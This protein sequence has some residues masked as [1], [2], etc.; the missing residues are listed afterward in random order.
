MGAIA[1]PLGIRIEDFGQDLTDPKGNP[2]LMINFE[3]L[4]GFARSSKRSGVPGVPPFDAASGWDGLKLWRRT[5]VQECKALIE[6]GT[7]PFQQERQDTICTGVVKG[8]PL[9]AIYDFCQWLNEGKGYFDPR[10]MCDCTPPAAYVYGGPLP[11]FAC[12]K[13][14]ENDPS[15]TGVIAEWQQFLEDFYQTSWHLKIKEDAEFQAAREER[16]QR[17]I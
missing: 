13:A 11:S 17:R 2:L 4:L 14:H 10:T 1:L 5:L 6:D 8:Y 16:K 3:S 9:L 7:I 15:I 12:A